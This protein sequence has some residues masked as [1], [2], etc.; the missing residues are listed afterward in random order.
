MKKPKIVVIGGCNTDMIVK[1]NRLPIPGETVLGGSFSM[2]PGGKGANQSIAAARLGG[3]ITLIAKTGNDLFS[4]KAIELFVAEG[5]NRNYVFSDPDH[6]SGVALIY[7]DINNNFCISVAPGANLLLSPKDIE[8]AKTEIINADI[9]LI[10]LEIPLDTVEY[11]VKL[12]K[13]HNVRVVLNPD[14]A[15]S[16][17]NEIIKSLYVI[18]PND[19][20]AGIL[21]G[22]K[23]HNMETAEKAAKKIMQKGI[24]NVIITLGEKGVFLKEGKNNHEIKALPVKAIDNLGAGDTFSGALSVA[25]AEGKSLLDAAIFANAAAAITVTR[26]GV[27]SATPYRKEVKTNI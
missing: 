17:N 12:A 9:L 24:D 14:P 27:Q 18:V 25:L 11:A 21:S 23:V 7:N 6:P 8:K 15:A 4:C 26:S 20:E 3:D 2:S 13:Q 1:T 22:V 19:V 5:I 10:Q 16:L